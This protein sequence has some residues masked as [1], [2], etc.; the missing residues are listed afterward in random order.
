MKTTHALGTLLVS[1]ASVGLVACGGGDDTPATPATPVQTT[2]TGSA[3][4][5]PVNSA[6][7][8]AK[9]AADGTA[10]GTATT[11]NGTYTLTTTCTGDLVI[12]VTGGTYTDE[13]TKA[14]TSLTSPLKVM[15]TANG[16]N[17]K[18]VATPFTTLAF[19]SSFGGTPATTAAFANQ[20]KKVAQ[21]FGM[22]NVD[23]ATTTPNVQDAKDM[24]GAYLAAVSGYLNG[25]GVNEFLQLNLQNNAAFQ[26]AFRTALSAVSAYS[27]TFDAS[28]IIASSGT[29]GTGGTS[30]TGSTTGTGT[31][32]TGTL[33]VT[34]SA[35]GVGIPAVTIQNIPVPASQSDFCGELTNDAT[36][37][38]MEQSGAK[39][40]VSSC[41]FVNK[42]GNVV[43]T[44]Q[45]T[46][47]MAM[48]VPY[49]LT[50][51]Y[52]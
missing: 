1:V 20:A 27:I 18:A 4:K 23:L 37:R 24:Y 15:V 32:G 2:I 49:N 10:C 26:S 3:V 35:M 11:T 36:F 38:S 6:T 19:S 22:G 45:I 44:L 17:A 42:V 14:T 21:Y 7:V 30:G 41:S 13:A 34:G 39:F 50:Y 25:K 16:G 33:T 48:T 47:P 51:T 8:T 29:T 46:T 12:E 5:G 31:S 52:K 9:K 43:A 28:A 40:T